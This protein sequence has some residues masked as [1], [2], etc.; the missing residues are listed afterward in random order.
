MV[1]KK[2]ASSASVSILSVQNENGASFV[3]VV[4]RVVVDPSPFSPSFPF[5]ALQLP[6]LTDPSFSILFSLVERERVIRLRSIHCI[7]S[8]TRRTLALHPFC[9]RRQKC[10]RTFALLLFSANLS[11]T[12]HHHARHCN[13]LL[14]R[15]FTCHGSRCIVRPSAS[16][17]AT[18]SSSSAGR[19]TVT[20][21]AAATAIRRQRSPAAATVV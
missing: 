16:S 13:C 6:L 15:L 3:V 18:L 4:F 17:T 2:S 1:T 11:F 14:G 7:R 19:S 10:S 20:L 12:N 8:D 21:S 9:W 5:S